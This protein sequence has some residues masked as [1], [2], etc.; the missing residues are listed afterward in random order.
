MTSSVVA[1]SRSW[2]RHWMIVSGGRSRVRRRWPDHERAGR[3]LDLAPQI[4]RSR[5]RFRE[6]AGGMLELRARHLVPPEY[7]TPAGVLHR[8]VERGVGLDAPELTERADE[9][10]VGHAETRCA[11]IAATARESA[12]EGDAQWQSGAYH[13]GKPRRH[14]RGGQ[15]GAM[16]TALIGAPTKAPQ[17]RQRLGPDPADLALILGPN[18]A[19]PM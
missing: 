15:R 14:A 10:G 4:A 19:T 2:S 7:H 13:A 9:R 18:V 11:P 3:T 17:Y 12:D 1:H 6:H 5:R 16:L 8:D